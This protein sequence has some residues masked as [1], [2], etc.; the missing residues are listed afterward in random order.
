M[1][2]VLARTV[3]GIRWYLR[4]ATGEARWD[5]YVEHC[6]RH[7]HPPMSRRDFERQRADAKES[8]PQPRCC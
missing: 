2:Q 7:G 5:D 6:R 3:R 1:R 4:E 8:N